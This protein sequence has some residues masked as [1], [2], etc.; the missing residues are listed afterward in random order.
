MS[1]VIAISVFKGGTGKTTTAVSLAADLKTLGARVLLIDLDQQATATKYVGLN[2]EEKP[3]LYNVFL[4]DVNIGSAIRELPFGFYA[5]PANAGLAAIEDALEEGDEKL[6]S[7]FIS[8]IRDD[9]DYVVIDTPPGKAGLTINALSA[10]DEVIITLQTERPALEGVNDLIKFTHD[11]V[12]RYNDKLTIRGILPTMYRKGT[13]HTVGILKR[14]RHLWKDF[15]FPVEIPNTIEFS[16]SFEEKTPIVMSNPR[17]PG[18]QA[19]MQFARII[20]GLPLEHTEI[21]HHAEEETDHPES[22]GEAGEDAQGDENDENMVPEEETREET[23]KNI[24]VS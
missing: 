5:I 14:A 13:K 22:G 16:R 17:H 15:V 7:D 2:P 8:G 9:F 19:Y 4:K 6:L 24:Q 10:A 20:H 3:T 23:S 1:K 12:F 18:A 11:I 21:E